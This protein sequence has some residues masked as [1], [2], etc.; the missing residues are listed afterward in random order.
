MKFKELFAD[1]PQQIA[2]MSALASSILKEY[3]DSIIGAAQ[4]DYM[5]AK[6]QSEASIR[7]QLAHGYRY[8]F[9]VTQEQNAGF[10][11]FYPRN[12]A[13]YLSKLYLGKSQRGKGFARP[14]LDFVVAEAKKAGLNAVELNVNKHNPSCAIYERLGFT[15]LRAEKNDIGSGFYMD[16]YVY[17]LEF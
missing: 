15:I 7:E 17:R 9:A 13:M 1:E 12:D 3:Y 14:I 8:F 10:L 11:A 4:N 5:I 16:D 6:F 2:A